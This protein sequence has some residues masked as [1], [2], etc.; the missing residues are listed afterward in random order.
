MADLFYIGIESEIKCR[1]ALRDSLYEN[2]KARRTAL[3]CFSWLFAAL[4]HF[5]RKKKIDHSSYVS[6]HFFNYIDM[7]CRNWFN[8]LCVSVYQVSASK[9]SD[10]IRKEI[11]IEIKEQKCLQII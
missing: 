11:D 2:K 10:D 7:K 4:Y 6:L 1:S 3:L 5:F 9:A 8:R